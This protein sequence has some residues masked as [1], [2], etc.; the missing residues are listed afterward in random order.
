M[1]VFWANVFHL[2]WDV[3]V[4]RVKL[5][6]ILAV[7]VL[8]RISDWQNLMRFQKLLW[9]PPSPR[10]CI[11]PAALGSQLLV[12]TQTDATPFPLTFLSL[13]CTSSRQGGSLIRRGERLSSRNGGKD[14]FV[15]SL[16]G[17]NTNRQRHTI[18]ADVSVIT[19]HFLPT[20]LA[21]DMSR[22]TA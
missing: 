13:P 21:T 16:T 4:Q 2:Q 9:S 14:C 6:H 1:Y 22:W 3:T 11:G 8:P 20:G 15:P 5:W 17:P 10:F 7:Q 12:Q 19:L 18:S